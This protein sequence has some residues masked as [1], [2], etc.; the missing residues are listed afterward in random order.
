MCGQ[1]VVA[2]LSWLVPAARAHSDEKQGPSPCPRPVLVT[3]LLRHLGPGPGR[4]AGRPAREP[5]RGIRRQAQPVP[6]GGGP[7]RPGEPR[8]PRGDPPGP[9]RSL[10]ALRR[11]LTE[12]AALT[13][14]QPPRQDRRGCLVGNTTA[15]L[16]P[17]DDDAQALVAAAYDGFIKVAAAALK[18]AQA[19]GGSRGKQLL[20]RRK[21][22]CCCSCFRV[23]R[24]SR[25]PRPLATGSTPES[26]PPWT[27]C[28]QLSLIRGLS[29]ED[30]QPTSYGSLQLIR[31]RTRL[32]PAATFSTASKAPRAWWH[33]TAQAN[34][35]GRLAHTELSGPTRPPG[36][37][38]ATLQPAHLS[39]K[40]TAAARPHTRPRTAQRCNPPRVRERGYLPG[41]AIVQAEQDHGQGRL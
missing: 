32:E 36:T 9:D 14:A 23:L 33:V 7:L 39:A 35:A 2:W 41:A 40:P 19:S 29:A 4:R 3:R 17:G 16:V 13:G 37:R 38:R 10:P 1:E 11:I 15:E 25:A 20:R 8:T 34:T 26:T 18:R 22:R 28:G 12:P 30:H 24:W 6:E 5:V 31:L 27:H 21:P